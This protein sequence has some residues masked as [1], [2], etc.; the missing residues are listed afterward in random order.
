M[1]E[2]RIRISMEILETGFF[3]FFYAVVIAV[4]FF[5]YMVPYDVARRRKHPQ[6]KSI[7]WFNALLGFT[8]VGWVI[9]LIW[10]YR[11]KSD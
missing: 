2:K 8:I 4:T 11:H 3:F 9:A 6:A 5:I 10:S 1:I 7:L